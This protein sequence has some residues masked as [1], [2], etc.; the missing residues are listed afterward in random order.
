MLGGCL[1]LLQ[2]S[3]GEMYPTNR[4]SHLLQICHRSD[5]DMWD[6][7][8]RKFD[9]AVIIVM[10]PNTRL[11]NCVKCLVRLRVD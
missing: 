10:L 9:N 4:A 3:L 11:Q 5:Y 1:T 7:W 6:I 2:L 8:L